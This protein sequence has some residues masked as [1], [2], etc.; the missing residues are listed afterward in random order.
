M[1]REASFDDKH[2]LASRSFK[3]HPIPSV[4]T[5]FDVCVVSSEEL[6]PEAFF[7]AENRYVPVASVRSPS[8]RAFEGESVM[9]R[10]KLG[11]GAY[12]EVYCYAREEDLANADR[13]AIATEAPA[14][15]ALKISR[16][17]DESAILRE[18]LDTT[19][20][21]DTSDRFV[22]IIPSKPLR[23]I[24]RDDQTLS[25]EQCVVRDTRGVFSSYCVMPTCMCDLHTFLQREANRTRVLASGEDGFLRIL[26][27]ILHSMR[28]LDEHD[29]VHTDLKLSNILVREVDSEGVPAC[30]LG[31][32][33]SIA[34]KHVAH[35]LI[36][37]FPS[38]E[39]YTHG[40][41][42]PQRLW[43]V[44]AFISEYSANVCG[45]VYARQLLYRDMTHIVRGSNMQSRDTA[46]IL[47]W[48]MRVLALSLPPT[49]RLVRK[50][51]FVCAGNDA[52]LPE[53]RLSD[54]IGLIESA[55][56]ARTDVDRSIVTC[57]L[58]LL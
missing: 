56:K 52:S 35:K 3:Y 45:T 33:G 26:K 25:V 46:R 29:M 30:E 32:I 19:M 31:D 13:E 2:F 42:T 43:S 12:G 37:T 38:P 55:E 23:P 47:R 17:N 40:Y 44:G 1:V 8:Y 15:L 11:G 16:C 39:Y 36:S 20:F 27:V 50:L 41:E 10:S 53:P 51:H 6:T 49:W 14:H 48:N 7:F 22:A 57:I 34:P 21:G 5:T 28:F 58:R 18:C 4:D 9:D 54:L 24:V